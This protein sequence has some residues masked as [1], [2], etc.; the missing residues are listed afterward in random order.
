M[1]PTVKPNGGISSQP[2]RADRQNFSHDT[3]FS[4][5]L[6]R[7]SLFDKL[8]LIST[9]QE[10]PTYLSPFSQSLG[11][12][13]LEHSKAVERLERFEQLELTAS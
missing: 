1:I 6:T 8:L 9:F 12:K 2:R 7:S 4:P 11:F 13:H 3:K 10:F 5:R